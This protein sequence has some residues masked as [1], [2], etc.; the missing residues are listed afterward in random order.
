MAP[1]K[2][3]RYVMTKVFRLKGRDRL[4][5]LEKLGKWSLTWE[6]AR[7]RTSVKGI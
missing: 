5:E 3:G 1:K 7:S 4:S 6:S 2:G